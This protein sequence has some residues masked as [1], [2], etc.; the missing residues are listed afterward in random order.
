[1]ADP[2]DN[3]WRECPTVNH[4]CKGDKAKRRAARQAER[5]R[6]AANLRER[7]ERERET[8]ERS[9]VSPRTLS[10]LALVAALGG[11]RG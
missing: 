9:P 10:L 7:V 1:M 6:A 5:E 11:S 4:N 3:Y 8:M 2:Y